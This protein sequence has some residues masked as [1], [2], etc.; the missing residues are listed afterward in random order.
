MPHDRPITLESTVSRNFGVVEAEIK[1]EI[2]AMNIDTGNCY[3]LN[4]VGSRIWSLLADPVQIGGLCE[5][6]ITE[7]QVD[8]EVC[9]RDVLELL[10]E[11]Y[12]EELIS[13]S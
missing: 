2:V 3:G 9:E 13:V 10:R 1:G 7:F 12:A 11:L 8:P 6:L 5:Q 4:S